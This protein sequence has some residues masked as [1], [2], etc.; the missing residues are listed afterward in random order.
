MAPSDRSHLSVNT[1]L[2]CSVK[3]RRSPYSPARSSRRSPFSL[4]S[5][6]ARDHNPDLSPPFPPLDA[7]STRPR[8]PSSPSLHHSHM[9]RSGWGKGRCHHFKSRSVSPHERHVSPSPSH[10]SRSRSPSISLTRPR[11]LPPVPGV[12]SAALFRW[13]LQQ[14]TYYE[15]PTALLSASAAAAASESRSAATGEPQQQQRQQQQ[16]QQGQ[17]QQQQQQQQ[18]GAF[19]IFER[20][21]R[22]QASDSDFSAATSIR[23]SS[24]S[25]RSDPDSSS[26]SSRRS[27]NSSSSSSSHGD[28]G[29]SSSISSSYRDGSSGEFGAS[30]GVGREGSFT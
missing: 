4:L 30:G 22:Q 25:N 9:P 18:L 28:S 26:R 2:R 1:Y 20:R 17:G 19:Q 23:N 8:S 13:R 27:T 10:D 3:R 14:A 24:S 15:P 7:D 16:Q 6:Q 11:V 5:Q 21:L 29:S 12:S